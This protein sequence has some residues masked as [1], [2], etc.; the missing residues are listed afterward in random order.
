M[1]GSELRRRETVTMVGTQTE[2][3]KG[4]EEVYEVLPNTLERN[5]PVRQHG[6]LPLT[7]DRIL[8]VR[9]SIVTFTKARTTPTPTADVPMVP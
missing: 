5:L 4:K 9:Q 8:L 6:V 7:L 2:K 1:T 3:E